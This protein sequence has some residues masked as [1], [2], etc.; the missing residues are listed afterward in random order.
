MKRVL[1][2][3]LCI[4]LAAIAVSA[5][6]TKSQTPPPAKNFYKVVF[7]ISESENGKVTNQ[8]SY[9]MTVREDRTA[10]MKTGNRIPIA[11][12]NAKGE[13]VQIQYMDVGFNADATVN[14]R[15]GKIEL[16]AMVDIT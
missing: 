3:T 16:D 15:D 12:G 2:I 6:D 10:Q 4:L 1:S 7:V 14:E 8:R 5:Q 9:S 11:T 13:N